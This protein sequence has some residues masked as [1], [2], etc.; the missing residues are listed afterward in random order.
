M[1]RVI[2]VGAS[3]VE[4]SMEFKIKDFPLMV[5]ITE[6]E[7]LGNPNCRE[8]SSGPALVLGKDTFSV[9]VVWSVAENGQVKDD[10][11]FGWYV[12][13]DH[14]S[15]LYL[16][17]MV[18]LRNVEPSLSNVYLRELKKLSVLT[19]VGCCPS[20][21]TPIPL[22]PL[23]KVLDPKNGWIID[24]AISL[25]CVLSM[26]TADAPQVEPACA[27]TSLPQDLGNIFRS[28]DLS[29]VTLVVGS[30]RLNAHSHI[31]AAR[32]PVFCKMFQ[33]PM[34][35]AST[36]EVVVED[37]DSA[38]MGHF[39]QFIYVGAL[40]ME[41]LATDQDALAILR[42]AHRYEVPSLM[43]RCAKVISGRLA[44]K[45]VAEVLQT[46]YVLG[47]IA[48]QHQCLGFVATHLAE[49]QETDGFMKLLQHY[50]A[51]VKELFSMVAPPKKKRRV[52]GPATD[53]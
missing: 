34:K 51:L 26:V 11:Q 9:H 19:S 38:A 2:T 6:T 23:K 47:F 49:V 44:V 8:V 1:K 13:G 15:P 43:E 37:L 25:H 52:E 36:R 7:S 12:Q 5:L 3:V 17:I 39:L 32:S 10:S 29:D 21:P 14:K 42:V 22:M 18:Q 50:P 28:G 40:D 16:K 33:S 27:D 48:L 46:S 4:T 35:E 41:A 30:A 31:L 20:F 53:E 45:S 24:N